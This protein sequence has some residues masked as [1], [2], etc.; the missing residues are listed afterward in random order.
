MCACY[1]EEEEEFQTVCK[2]GTGFSDENL[3]KFYKFFSEEGKERILDTKPMEYNVRKDAATLRPDIWLKASMVWEVKAADLSISPAHTAA[4]GDAHD[5]KGIALRFPRL[6]RVRD[7]KDVFDATSS[8][9]V[10]TMF[11][12][13]ANRQDFD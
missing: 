4:I 12:E 1:N 7:D 5:T 10:L 13:Q 2:I 9:Q 3:E 11:N 6:L 8:E